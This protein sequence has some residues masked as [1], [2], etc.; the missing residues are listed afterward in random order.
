MKYIKLLENWDQ[1]NKPIIDSNISLSQAM[2]GT[3][4]P[5]NITSDLT[6]IDVN[7][8][9]VDK[10]LHKGQIIV[11]KDL[12]SDV[13]Q[14]FAILLQDKFIVVKVIPIVKYNWNDDAS[15]EDNNSSGF[16]FR[17]V[18]GKKTLSKHSMGR[19]IDIN[20][21]WNPVYYSSGKISP[22][23]ATRDPK[24][25]G[26]FTSETRGVQ[27]LKAKG[28]KWGGDWTSLKDWHHFEKGE[29]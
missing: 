2:Q 4:A 11:H 17:V 29:S 5:G 14:F 7:Y 24:K 1:S 19:A 12:V 28:W 20:P 3:L 26:V 9:S 6:M 10:K 22:Q 23:G 21:L 16:N 18:E 15:M 8:L 25:E 13:K 27:F